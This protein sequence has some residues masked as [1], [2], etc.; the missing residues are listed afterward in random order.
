MNWIL[1]MSPFPSPGDA[2]TST[3]DSSSLLPFLQV[4]LLVPMT[5][6][7]TSSFSSFTLAS[8]H[9]VFH[10]FLERRAIL[11]CVQITVISYVLHTWFL[12]HDY[13][14]RCICVA[15]TSTLRWE[16]RVKIFPRLP[17]SSEVIAGLM[18]QQL[19]NTLGV[20]A[21]A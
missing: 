6:G 2:A 1:K 9:G 5:S 19:H 16:I 7:P 4:Y 17:L 8:P 13:E 21:M 15:V 10:C 18:T 20:Y 14:A 3:F 11:S 12:L